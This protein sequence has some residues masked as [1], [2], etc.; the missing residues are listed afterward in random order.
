[1]GHSIP[2]ISGGMIL[3]SKLVIISKNIADRANTNV[4]TSDHRHNVTPI[5]Y[6]ESRWF[7]PR[8]QGGKHKEFVSF[9]V[10]ESYDVE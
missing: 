4:L 1:M 3:R 8:N 6:S 9:R 7:F 2:K 5:I 10:W